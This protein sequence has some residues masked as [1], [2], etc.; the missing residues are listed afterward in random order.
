MN[1]ADYMVYSIDM[2]PKGYVFT[3]ADFVTRVDKNE[4]L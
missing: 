4:A 1:F 3:Y 2:L